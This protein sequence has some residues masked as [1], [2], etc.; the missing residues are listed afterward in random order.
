MR[1]SHRV[2]VTAFEHLSVEEEADIFLDVNVNAKPVKPGLVME[3]EY[4]TERV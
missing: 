2:L 1:E 4:S 3:I